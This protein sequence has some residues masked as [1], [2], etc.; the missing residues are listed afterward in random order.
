[1]ILQSDQVVLIRMI[2]QVVRWLAVFAEDAGDVTPPTGKNGI[3]FR[4]AIDHAI[5][6][7]GEQGDPFVCHALAEGCCFASD[8]AS[9]RTQ[10]AWHFCER[11]RKPRYG[12]W[13]SRCR[14]PEQ[15]DLW[16][17]EKVR[18]VVGILS[19]NRQA[20]VVMTLPFSF[21]ASQLLIAAAVSVDGR[22]VVVLVI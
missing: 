9:V 22:D 21:S 20:T 7:L 8:L 14:M 3:A 11:T 1:M 2:A 17:C 10:D 12:D 15:E 19:V 5:E 6:Q 13:G 18:V 4:V 16:A